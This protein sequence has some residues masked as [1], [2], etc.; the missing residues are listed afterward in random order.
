MR[1]NV[2]RSAGANGAGAG[3]P[4]MAGGLFAGSGET[5]AL[6]RAFDWAGSPLGAVEDWPS[7]LRAT[8]RLVLD[9]P[10]PMGLYAG[11]EFVTL[12]NDAYRAILGAKHP[13]AFGR[14]AVEVWAEL[15]GE[16]G[17]QYVGVREG[18]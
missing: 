8:A 14:P 1:Q 18:G 2:I 6:G 4:G 3:P 11:P 13:A 15:W 9:S 7:A 16:I 17:P 12:Y 5:R 10:V